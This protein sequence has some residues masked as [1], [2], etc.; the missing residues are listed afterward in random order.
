MTIEELAELL[1]DV[2]IDDG[3]QVY[4]SRIV[5]GMC[6]DRELLKAVVT[7]ELKKITE[8]ENKQTEFR[9]G[10]IVQYGNW[11]FEIKYIYVDTK[12]GTKRYMIHDGS[13]TVPAS[14]LELIERRK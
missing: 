14:E 11:I 4:S 1:I 10:D 8:S 6:Y 9:V 13:F 3:V 5:H 7:Q 12:D 2:N